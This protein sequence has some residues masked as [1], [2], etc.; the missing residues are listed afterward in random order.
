MVTFAKA[1]DHADGES[2]ERL[3]FDSQTHPTN[4][5]VLRVILPSG[6]LTYG[7]GGPGGNS[8]SMLVSSLVARD[9]AT[10]KE[11]NRSTGSGI[12]D[13]FAHLPVQ[14]RCLLLD[15]TVQRPGKLLIPFGG[16]EGWILLHRAARLALHNFPVQVLTCTASSKGFSY[17]QNR[18]L[19]LHFQKRAERA[20]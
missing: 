13:D 20:E 2:F 8:C 18:I 19:R 1:A 17:A 12:S 11:F 10:D 3:A 14:E 4:F 9:R 16:G 5:C 15:V 7:R 6:R